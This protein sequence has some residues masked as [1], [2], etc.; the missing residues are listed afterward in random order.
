MKKILF[1][2]IFLYAFVYA[3]SDKPSPIPLPKSVFLDIN[4]AVCNETCL[5]RLLSNGQLFSFMS[6]YNEE[7]STKAL[8]EN[9]L[10]YAQVFNLLMYYEYDSEN[11][12]L[13][14]LI[15]QK[16]IK[17][18]ALT[19]VNAVLAYLLRQRGDFELAVFNSIDESE[20]AIRL[21]LNEIRRSG[22]LY[23]I[24]PITQDGLDA[25]IKNGYG[26]Y[27]FIPTLHKSLYDSASDNIIFGGIDYNAQIEALN[28][29]AKE[30][31]IIFSGESKLELSLNDMV[32]NQDVAVDDTLYFT[33]LKDNFKKA[34]ENN[35]KLSSSSVYLNMPRFMSGLLASQLRAYKQ[36][37]LAL[38]STQ[39]NYHPDIL[40]LT[41]Y[42]DRK[43]LYLANSIGAVDAHLDSINAFL[44]NNMEYD[45]VNYS[46]SIGVEYINVNFFND[47]FEKLFSEDINSYNQIEY[48][49]N[50]FKAG[51]YGFI[52][53]DIRGLD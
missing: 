34:I 45:W 21:T 43:N 2:L 13:A 51:Q 36:T 11:I 53:Q 15:P 38:L 3:F 48:D 16:S 46:I 33:S 35:K 41:Q 1:M 8:D 23:V 44:G 47:E 9:Y 10:N 18:Y 26:M 32:K 50:I 39:I 24:A 52:K 27:I 17:N 30:N 4:P 42:E 7:Y 19:S 12:K 49:T 40:N 31:I 29:F 14:V 6:R 22:Y 25:L 28:N 5:D 20:E 37:P